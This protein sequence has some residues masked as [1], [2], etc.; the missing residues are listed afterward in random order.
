MIEPLRGELAG[1]LL[2]IVLLHNP[3]GL[4]LQGM[5][6][7]PNI[8]LQDFVVEGRIHGSINYGNLSRSWSRKA[9]PNHHSTAIIFDCWYVL[10]VKCCVHLMPDAMGLTPFLKKKISFFLASPQN[11]CWESWS[12]LKKFETSLYLLFGQKWLFPY[13]HICPFSFLFL[14]HDH[15]P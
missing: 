2:I 8:L 4:K 1:M 12:F 7:L 11:I 9:A 5:N 10:F 15:W 3:T 13:G 14:N 6:W